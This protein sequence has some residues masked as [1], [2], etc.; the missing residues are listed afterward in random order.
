MQEEMGSAD[1]KGQKEYNPICLVIMSLISLLVVP[2]F[3]RIT[4]SIPS[5]F[6]S[7]NSLKYII[8][9]EAIKKRN[10]IKNPMK[11]TIPKLF[12][13]SLYGIAFE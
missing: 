5:C 1:Y 4:Y 9:P 10:A 3:L 13:V 12:L 7:L 2:I 6:I 11:R 8:L